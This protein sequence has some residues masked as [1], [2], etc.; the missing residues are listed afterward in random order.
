[1]RQIKTGRGEI[2]EKK[3]IRINGVKVPKHLD[4]TKLAQLEARTAF[5]GTMNSLNFDGT[6][7]VFKTQ[8]YQVGAELFGF[9]K[10]HHKDW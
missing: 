10:K 7:E 5:A 6:R 4:A 3:R 9:V 2:E 1:M 8:V